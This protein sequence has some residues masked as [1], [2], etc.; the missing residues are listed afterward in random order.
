MRRA[1]FAMMATKIKETTDAKENRIQYVLSLWKR[2][3][4]GLHSYRLVFMVNRLV[5]F[6]PV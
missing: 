1:Y 6:K 2:R 4:G 5:E 3:V